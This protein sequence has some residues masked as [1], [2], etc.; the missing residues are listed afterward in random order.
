MKKRHRKEKAEPQLDRYSNYDE[1][2]F[3]EGAGQRTAAAASTSAEQ[4]SEPEQGE[5]PHSVEAGP[6][7]RILP[8]TAHDPAT[9]DLSA[10]GLAQEQSEKRPLS[11]ASARAGSFSK[12]S[13]PDLFL[14]STAAS[15]AQ[16]TALRKAESTS[17]KR[18]PARSAD[19]NSV[20]KQLLSGEGGRPRRRRRRKE[21]LSGWQIASRILIAFLIFVFVLVVGIFALWRY[22]IGTAKTGVKDLPQVSFKQNGET[23]TTTPPPPVRDGQIINILLMGLDFAGEGEIYSRS[24]TMMLATIDQKNNKLKLTS[25]QR[26]MLVYLP[27]TDHPVKLNAASQEGP[28]RLIETLNNTFQ[29]D[30]HD[31]IMFNINGAEDIIDAVGG[32]EVDVPTDPEVLK[33]LNRLIEEQNA[34]LE[35]WDDAARARWSPYVWRGGRQLLNGRQAIAYARMRELDTDFHRMNR[36]QEVVELLVQKVKSNLTSLPAVVRSGLSH[37]TTNL[38]DWELTQMGLSILPKIGNG[39]DRLQIPIQGYFWMDNG[40]TWCIRANFNLITPL[41]HNF[42]Y[43]KPPAQFTAVALPPYT[44][45]AKTGLEQMPSGVYSG[46]AADVPYT[47]AAGDPGGQLLNGEEIL[48]AATAMAQDA[49]NFAGE[50]GTA[51]TTFA[52]GAGPAATPS[53]DLYTEPLPAEVNSAGTS[54][55]P[56]N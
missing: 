5:Q 37:V 3:V 42:V 2:I 17:G 35:G 16:P 32:V 49:D 43:G 21:K 7:N 6:A 24:D 4:A 40:E 55:N 27:G 18:R 19:L 50:S 23:L 34:A 29:L 51:E 31:Y 56:E 15:G 45:L 41:L 28:Q 39:I 30:I 38:T 8:A 33:Y 20:K 22:T 10:A 25:F 52:T 54:V 14:P 53:A 11:S 47:G 26:D 44:P 48:A 1:P 9:G 12:P 13:G 46:L 36:Q